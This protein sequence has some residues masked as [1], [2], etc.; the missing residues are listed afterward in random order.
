MN[1]LT[2]NYLEWKSQR[3]RLV[4]LNFRNIG[5]NINWCRPFFKISIC[6]KVFVW[7]CMLPTFI[8]MKIKSFSCA[9]YASC[10]STRSAKQADGNSEVEEKFA[11]MSQV[12][13]VFVLR[14]WSF[15]TATCLAKVHLVEL[16]VTCCSNGY[17]KKDVSYR[18]SGANGPSSSPGR[19]HCVVFLGKTLYS[20][21][22]SLHPSV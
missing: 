13:I 4:W 15:V 20:H 11:H 17:W 21:G 18:D 12:V 22:A 16:H 7:K 3:N 9:A 1:L 8:L 10:T 14:A 2:Y 6:A 19:G 5:V